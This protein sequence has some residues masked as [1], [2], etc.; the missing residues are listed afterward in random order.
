MRMKRLE[1]ILQQPYGVVCKR[2]LI[3][4]VLLFVQCPV[5]STRGLG[6]SRGLCG[7]VQLLGAAVARCAGLDAESEQRSP[8]PAALG[9]FSV[10]VTAFCPLWC[11]AKPCL[12]EGWI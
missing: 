8:P 11:C 12:R 10:P 1:L 5:W 4:F 3:L 6:R 2:L 7:C 9:S